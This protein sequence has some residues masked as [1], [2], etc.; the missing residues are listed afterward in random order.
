LGKECYVEKCTRNERM[1][2]I[3][4]KAGIWKL[5]GIRWGFE[6]GRCPLC[7]GEEDAKHIILECCETNK[8]REKYVHSNWLNINEDLAYKT[9]TSCN[10][11]NRM[12]ALGTYLFKTKCKWENKV[13]GD[14]NPTPRVAEIG[15]QSESRNSKE[16]VMVTLEH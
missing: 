9:I 12:K 13:R 8:W 1:G 10:N 16:F 15:S 2:I 14:H 3:W 11:A 6:R 4:W 5:R 7:L